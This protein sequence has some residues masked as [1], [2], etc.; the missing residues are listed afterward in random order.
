MELHDFATMFGSRSSN[1]PHFS[2]FVILA[3]YR[4]GVPVETAECWENILDTLRRAALLALSRQPMPLLQREPDT[5]NRSDKG[6]YV[7]LEAEGGARQLALMATG[8][9][10][11]LAVQARKVLQTEG[12]PTPVVSMTCRLLFEGQDSKRCHGQTEARSHRS[13]G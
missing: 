1:W 4:P 6:A 10:L 7:L 11:H 12:V 3:V 5:E 2:A 8:S 9:E 13:R